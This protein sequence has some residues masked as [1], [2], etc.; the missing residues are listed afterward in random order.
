MTAMAT[1]ATLACTPQGTVAV[2]AIT[3]HRRGPQVT[4]DGQPGFYGVRGL[5]LCKQGNVLMSG[6]CLARKRRGPLAEQAE[7]RACPGWHERTLGA[8]A[9]HKGTPAQHRA[10]DGWCLHCS[11]DPWGA[12]CA[13]RSCGM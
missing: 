3:A 7:A 8:R 13:R 1:T 6:G 9:A 4:L 5:R 10:C 11:A 12:V 2:K